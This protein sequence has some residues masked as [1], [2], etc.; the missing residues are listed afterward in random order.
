MYKLKDVEFAI[1]N[2][3]FIFGESGVGST[4]LILN[5]AISK[6]GLELCDFEI[7]D[8]GVNIGNRSTF[9]NKENGVWSFSL[10]THRFH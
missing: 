3:G 6:Y 2:H 10:Y 4:G 1:C 7:W 8:I 5:L 9:E